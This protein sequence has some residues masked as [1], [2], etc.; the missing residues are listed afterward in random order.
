M[1]EILLKYIFYKNKTK[2][3]KLFLAISF[4]FQGISGLFKTLG[5]LLFD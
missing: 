1:T 2:F 4:I 3:H 5:V